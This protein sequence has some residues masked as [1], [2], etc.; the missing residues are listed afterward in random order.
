MKK[1]LALSVVLLV[2]ALPSFGSH[3]QPSISNQFRAKHSRPQ[4][5]LHPELAQHGGPT[6]PL[7]HA[8]KVAATSARTSNSHFAKSRRKS[9]N[10]PTTSVGLVTAPLIPFGGED[11]DET[12]PVMGDFNGDGKKDIAKLVE[13][14]INSTWTYQVSV[15]LSNGD[16]TFKP[17]QT[18][19]TVNNS[20]DP[21]FVGDLNGDGKDDIL[22]VHPSST[23]STVDVYLSKGDGT[24][25]LGTNA[26]LSAFTLN[27]G[28]LTDVNGDGKLDIL[29]VD[30]ENPA[31][32]SYVLGNGD[33]TFQATAT[34]ATLGGAAPN[35]I[36][37]AD[38]NGD[39]KLD[40]AG[41]VSGQVVVYLASGST[42]AAPVALLT[43]DTTYDSCQSIA[44]DLTGDT[45]PEIVSINCNDNTLTIFVNNGDGSFQTG[46]YY[47]NAGDLN[48]YPYA[49]SIADLNGDGKNDIVVANDDAGQI[50][51]FT[52]KG[53][54]TLTVPTVGYAVG[55]YSWEVPLVADFNG[56]GLL[57][58]VE[59]DDDF[60][61]AF[62]Q[63]Y[64]DGT[65]R[66][67]LGYY[68]PN[69]LQQ[70]SYSYSIGSGDFNG[71]GI[72]DVVIAQEGNS[73]NPGVIVFLSN[74]DGSLQP[75]VSY[76][77]STTQAYLT[78][79]D[80]N[81]DGKP[82][83]AATDY[84][85]G[86]VQIYM[87]KGDGTFT[88]GQAFATDT[89]GNPWPLNLVTGDFNHDGKLDLAVVNNDSET[90]GILLGNGDGTFGTP[91]P[92]A[93]SGYPY[94]LAAADLNGDGYLDLAVTLEDSNSSNLVAVFLANNDNSGTFKA[95][96]DIA[97]G[98][99]SAIYVAFGDLNGD[100]KPD[101]A[102][103][104]V[105]GPVYEGALVVALGNGDGT[106]Q[107]P[108]AYPSST[109]GGTS[110]WGYPSYL[111][112]A[113]FDGDGKLDLIYNNY[114]YGTVGIMYGKGDGTF[115]DAIDFATSEYDWGL[116]LADVNGDGAVDI[117]TPNYYGSGATVML[118]NSGSKTKPGY[119]VVSSQSSQTVKAGS[120][121]AYDLTLTG[122]NG[123][124]GTVTFSCS[125]LP[126]KSTCAFKPASVAAKG[127]LGVATTM[128]ITTT[129]A[130]TSD[131][132]MPARPKSN[133]DSSTLWASLSGLGVFG[134]VVA[135][136]DKKRRRNMSIVL[137]IVL[138]IMMFTLVGCSG[139]SSPA[140][141][142]PTTVPGTPAGTYT[143]VVHATGTGN[144][145]RSMNVKLVV[146]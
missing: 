66:S 35:G 64:G 130:T 29:T 83:I 45:K 26:Q 81:S 120:S 82:D 87:G 53:D 79:A 41:E 97:T 84:S 139:N 19:S 96:S 48:M 134:M 28:I 107:A 85:S 121:A 116:V 118:N 75:G 9:A 38:F 146:Q 58:V 70:N 74:A 62:L 27:G 135:G 143:I 129:A 113:D 13:N 47:Q 73:N 111:T 110:G 14:L 108:T 57:D 65:F 16:G 77:S 106:F 136:A 55:G 102:A 144:V 104:V 141:V 18:T 137:G 142:T 115:Y 8:Q 42:F 6:A 90:I 133:P 5:K 23:P 93:I 50:T 52:G 2:A 54:G 95:E 59:S 7:T 20:D 11:D 34:L 138:L 36:F 40:F 127:N 89:A 128:T 122:Q 12:S 69:D 3:T 39:G 112:M 46:V 86:V 61:F 71:D 17:A 98:T 33:G 131:L 145:T 30:S 103:S 1:Y 105:S 60:A 100:G 63:G 72:P 88:V 91:T 24:F 125:G 44:G 126:S 94:G 4:P 49:A 37:F 21:I 15:V 109:M 22:Q 92:Y 140:T 56:D 124:N 132:M 117:V 123:Y 43:S 101:M 32:V 51:L 99:G 68:A 114:E 67:A 25:T 31:V 78:V 10:S 119:S 76:G 80:F